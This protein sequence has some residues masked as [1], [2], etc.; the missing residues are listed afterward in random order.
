MGFS[1]VFFFV[2]TL[3]YVL[4]MFGWSYGRPPSKIC[5]NRSVEDANDGGGLAAAAFKAKRPWIVDLKKKLKTKPGHACGWPW[6]RRW[7]VKIKLSLGIK[8]FVW[9]LLFF[10]I[11][12]LLWHSFV[13]FYGG[14]AE[15][16]RS[17]LVDCVSLF[18]VSICLNSKEAREIKMKEP[19]ALPSHETIK[20]GLLKEFARAWR[21]STKKEGHVNTFFTAL[22]KEGEDMEMAILVLWI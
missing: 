15:R 2:F 10:F 16:E 18:H 17:L 13:A 22:R 11:L 19:L 21:G 6:R 12:T 4:R 8:I 3:F 1:S 9:F 20:M 7:P 5:T 14:R